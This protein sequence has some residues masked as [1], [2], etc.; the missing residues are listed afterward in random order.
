MGVPHTRRSVSRKARSPGESLRPASRAIENSRVSG[1]RRARR[2][3]SSSPRSTSSATAKRERKA[4]PR[5]ARAARLTASLEPSSQMPSGLDRRRLAAPRRRATACS[6]PASRA[7]STHVAESGGSHAS[8]FTG[9][10]PVARRRRSRPRRT[11]RARPA[12]RP[13]YAPTIASCTRPARSRS[14][15][16]PQAA[17]ST[18]TRTFGEVAAEAAERLRG[19]GRHRVRWRRRDESC[20]S[21]GR[22]A[23]RAPH[24]R[25]RA[26]R[27]PGRRG[28]RGRA[29]ASVSLLPRPSRS[30]SAL[31]RGELEQAQMLADA[32]LADPDR[33]RGAPRGTPGARSRP[34]GASGS[35]PRGPTSGVRESSSVAMAD[36]VRFGCAD[37]LGR[38]YCR[39]HD[40]AS[41]SRREHVVRELPVRLHLAAPAGGRRS[42]TSSSSTATSRTA[43]AIGSPIVA[44][45]ETHVQADHVSGLARPRRADGCDRLSA[46][47]RGCRVRAHR[48]R[49]RRHRR[50]RQHDR[51][52]NFDARVTRPPIL[53][54]PL[55]TGAAARPTR[56]SCSRATRCSSVTSVAPI[57][58]RKAIRRLSR[59]SCTG[60]SGSCFEL[61]DGVIVYPSHIGGSVCGR[62]LSSNPFSSIGFERR[63]NEALSHEDE[64]AFVAA[65]L[66]DVPPPPVDQAGSSPGT[67]AVSGIQ[68]V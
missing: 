27:A 29:P 45:F 35:C 4:K 57:C 13:P 60:R 54:S 11:V 48:A 28:R 36:I 30:T 2:K 55:P 63:H 37:I 46:R 61:D 41:V 10:D 51:H 56:G 22:Q 38:P 64:D 67:A 15:I 7:S 68:P 39:M 58:T 34:A 1:R 19:A 65:L 43:A 33:S 53:P 50:A 44:V 59:A 66:V 24:R 26:R 52:R 8:A 6:T 23:R 25:R 5:P 31:S 9:G 3:R 32:R 12:R 47:E 49:R 20:R 62:G 18:W 16:S 21:A 40:P 17:I 14:R 42:R